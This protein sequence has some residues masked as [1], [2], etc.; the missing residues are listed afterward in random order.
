MRKNIAKLLI[1]AGLVVCPIMVSA[2]EFGI[3]DAA[4][5][6]NKYSETQKT[7]NMLESK[8]AAL[9]KKLEEKKDE[10]KKLND[11]YLELA[12]DIQKKRDAKKDVSASEKQMADIRKQLTAKDADLQKFYQDSQ[13]DLYAMEEKE[14]GALSKNL[15]SKVDAIIEKISKNY[16]LKAVFEKRSV[17]WQD[18]T[19]CKDITEEVIKSLNSGK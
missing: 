12:K 5:I 13:R 17:Y 10:V 2:A 6:F 15:D 14:M 3:I 4:Q 11:K 9:Q 7:K 8:K 19:A 16:K 18:K 1:I